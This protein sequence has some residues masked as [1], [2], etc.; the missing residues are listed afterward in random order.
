MCIVFVSL[1]SVLTGKAA[2]DGI[3]SCFQHKEALLTTVSVADSR[4][5]RAS[6]PLP[7]MV[8]VPDR[9]SLRLARN[10][11]LECPIVVK[12]EPDALQG[13]L[14]AVRVQVSFS[15]ERLR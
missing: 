8:V 11:R 1:F 3:S 5:Y 9:R 4:A 7:F 12:Q 6:I 15:F 13:V 10:N 14:Y 2:P